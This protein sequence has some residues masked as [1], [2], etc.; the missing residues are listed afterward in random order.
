[1]RLSQIFTERTNN[2]KLQK[3]LEEKNRNYD[4]ASFG[5]TSGDEKSSLKILS[6]D[7]SGDLAVKIFRDS[8]LALKMN[9]AMAA[10]Q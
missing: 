4:S 10:S 7:S 9:Q 6:S 8:P 1:M 2:D 5:E 3:Y